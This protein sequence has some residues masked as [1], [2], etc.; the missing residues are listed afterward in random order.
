MG[1]PE[2]ITV[3]GAAIKVGRITGFLELLLRQE[4]NCCV[5]APQKPN[6]NLVEGFI[7]ELKFRFYR[8]TLKYQTPIL[9]WDYLL[10][11]VC[12]ARNVVVNNYSYY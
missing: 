5:S 8:I 1:A 9:L 11:W 10:T 6:D 4:I 7:R 3:D 12:M 2:H